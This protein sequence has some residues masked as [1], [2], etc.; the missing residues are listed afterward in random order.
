MKNP[1]TVALNTEA[2][3]LIGRD[4]IIKEIADGICDAT[5]RSFSVIG[6]R[7][8]GTSALLRHLTSP[9][10]PLTKAWAGNAT[11]PADLNNLRLICVDFRRW[12][13]GLPVIPWF[14]SQVLAHSALKD[15]VSPSPNDSL[16]DL[17]GTL[18]RATTANARVVLA[19]NCFDHALRQLSKEEASRL[20]PIVEYASVITNTEV[21]I[22]RINWDFEQSPFFS[23][24]QPERNLRSLSTNE[25]HT[26][27]KGI[28]ND[29]YLEKDRKFL[30]SLTGHHPV[31]I[32]R[33]AE[34]W[35]DLRLELG[36]LPPRKFRQ[37]LK[38]RLES[39]FRN[40]LLY[41]SQL[42]RELYP[43]HYSRALQIVAPHQQQ[44]LSEEVAS[45]D[46][47]VVALAGLQKLGLASRDQRRQWFLFSD[48]WAEIIIQE[49]NVLSQAHTNRP[50]L[51]D[52]CFCQAKKSP[53]FNRKEPHLG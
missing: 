37:I 40:I 38:E 2:K 29:K 42:I 9:T 53:F 36:D 25:A 24:L 45:A 50:Q 51:A 35:Y 5:P 47:V 17:V 39:N 52:D 16:L 12:T 18:N 28:Y 49:A 22:A 8:L 27:L 19:L 1:F 21:P 10:G 46:G 41:Y 43:S 32:L 33:G 6:P 4:E 20:R 44:G 13:Y 15:F 14:A 26:L 11:T 48:L 31:L 3:Y 30:L 7:T 34:A 23:F